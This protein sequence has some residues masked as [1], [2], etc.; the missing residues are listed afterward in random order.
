MSLKD[1]VVLITSGGTGIGADA[2]RAFVNAGSRVVLNGRREG[3]LRKTAETID[4]AGKQVAIVA[5][6]IAEPETSRR[7][8]EVAVQRFGAVDV[9]FNNAGVFRPKPFL[10]V[11][12]GELNEYLRLVGG[13]YFAA[14]AAIA[15][16]R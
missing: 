10:H 16:M 5:G 3:E 8:V 15:E 14:Q 1:K 13:Y 11:T 12:P 4:R 2:A 7:M 9:L 6:D